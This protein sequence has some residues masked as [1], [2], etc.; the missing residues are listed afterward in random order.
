M[1]TI[2]QSD[3]R[4]TTGAGGLI[5]DVRRW[6]EGHGSQG[7]S[8]ARRRRQC[9]GSEVGGAPGGPGAAPEREGRAAGPKEEMGACGSH[10]VVW[11]RAELSF[12]H[13]VW[14][15][16]VGGI[17]EKETHVTCMFKGC[18]VESP[19]GHAEGWAKWDRA[20]GRLPCGAGTRHGWLH[21]V[22][23]LSERRVLR[24]SLLESGQAGG[25][26]VR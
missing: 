14:Q 23:P 7:P 16:D 10:R 26:L 22:W 11:A 12:Q 1:Q 24:V 17:K 6:P 9:K 19:R 8:S 2:K 21:F 20:E 18:P 3:G 25:G 15:E 4:G 5:L 13:R